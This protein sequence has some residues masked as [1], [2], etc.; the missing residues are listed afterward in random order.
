MSLPWPG[1]LFQSRKVHPRVL[2][3]VIVRAAHLQRRLQLTTHH[4]AR[5]LAK[6]F[7]AQMGIQLHARHTRRFALRHARNR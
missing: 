7:A 1:Q 3:A 5:G 4:W 2:S 6:D